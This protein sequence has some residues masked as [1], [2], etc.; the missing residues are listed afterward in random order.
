MEPL[1]RRHLLAEVRNPGRLAGMASAM[2]D[3]SDGLFIDLSRLCEESRVGARIFMQQLPLSVQMKKAA[4]FLG[5]KPDVFATSGGEDY[6]LLFTAPPRRRVNA[7]CIGEITDSERV[8]VG[9][10]G[11]ERPFSPEGYQHW[12]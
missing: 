2:I 12:R 1:L 10:D 7:V 8:V 3:V 5:R 4:A 11:S 6:E 9:R